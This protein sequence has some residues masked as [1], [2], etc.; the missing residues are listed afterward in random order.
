MFRRNPRK[1][2]EDV[3]AAQGLPKR[4]VSEDGFRIAGAAAGWS[5]D[6]IQLQLTLAKALGSHVQVGN[7]LLHLEGS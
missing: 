5:A 4:D 1:I 7:E 3:R 2:L 6:K